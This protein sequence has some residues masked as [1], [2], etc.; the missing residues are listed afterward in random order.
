MV[1]DSLPEGAKVR[2]GVIPSYATNNA[3]LFY[4]VFGEAEDRT[5]FIE[6]L[7]EKGIMAIF[8]Y[9]PLHKS[10]F[11]RQNHD[12]RSLPHAE[13]YAERLVRLPLYYDLGTH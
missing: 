1:I 5:V 9:L 6:R 12:G 10:P 11:Y 2:G 4:L 7:K 13:H 3:H 8:H